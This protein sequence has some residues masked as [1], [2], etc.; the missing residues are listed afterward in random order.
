MASLIVLELWV[1]QQWAKHVNC[2]LN[3]AD[4]RLL[5][6][7]DNDDTNDVDENNV[8]KKIG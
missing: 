3:N 1:D 8:I 4:Q 5:R 2:K 7:T 6:N